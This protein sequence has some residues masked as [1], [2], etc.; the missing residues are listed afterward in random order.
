MYHALDSYIFS[1]IQPLQTIIQLGL[2]A[3]TDYG[4]HC[5]SFNTWTPVSCGNA[6]LFGDGFS[7]AVVSLEVILVAA[8]SQSQ[9]E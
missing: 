6:S 2:W 5:L 3:A 1:E 4:K 8:E 9:S 7:V